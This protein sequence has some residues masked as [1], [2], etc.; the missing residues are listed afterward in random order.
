M[1][2]PMADADNLANVIAAF[3]AIVSAASALMSWQSVVASRESAD[4]ARRAALADFV[5]RWNERYGDPKFGQA[6]PKIKAYI[7]KLNQENKFKEEYNKK[8]ILYQGNRNSDPEFTAIHDSFREVRALYKS[9][10]IIVRIG[11]MKN[12]EVSAMLSRGQKKIITDILIPIG[13]ATPETGTV[14]DFSDL[15]AISS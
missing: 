2:V 10:S 8:F 12:C 3:A 13:E 4:I 1:E 7:E 15:R 14:P 9:L 6:I 5:S 11:A